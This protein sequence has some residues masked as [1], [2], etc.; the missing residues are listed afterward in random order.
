MPFWI[1]LSLWWTEKALPW[2]KRN[3]MWLLLPVG[4]ILFLLG[5]GSKPTR[6]IDVVST[7]L[8]GADAKREELKKELAE[9]VKELDDEKVDKISTVVK[10]HKETIEKLTNEQKGEAD[11][12]LGDPDKLNSYLLEVGRRVRD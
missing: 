5:R 1:V 6:K 11:N 12:L 7:K 9:K 8:H 3:W 4:I 10:E 2:L